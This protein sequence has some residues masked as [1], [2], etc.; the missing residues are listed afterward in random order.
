MKVEK[1]ISLQDKEGGLKEVIR[2]QGIC[3]KKYILTF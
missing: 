1:Y 2:K 3:K